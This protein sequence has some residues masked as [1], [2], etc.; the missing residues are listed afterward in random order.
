MSLPQSSDELYRFII[1]KR[2]FGRMGQIM[3]THLDGYGRLNGQMASYCMNPK[4]T[5]VEFA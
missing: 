3:P 5:T 1:D 4:L 2:E